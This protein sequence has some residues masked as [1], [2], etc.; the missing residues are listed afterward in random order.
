[1]EAQWYDYGS[2]PNTIPDCNVALSEFLV[3]QA[4]VNESFPET[5]RREAGIH[6]YKRFIRVLGQPYPPL[7][8]IMGGKV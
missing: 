8:K 4:G 6:S 2:L 7:I 3:K 1:V 5:L